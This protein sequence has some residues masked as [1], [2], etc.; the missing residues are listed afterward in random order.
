MKTI[1]A[2]R[3]KA[4]ESDKF[5]RML[6]ALG[7]G[8]SDSELARAAYNAGI[9]QAYKKLA[10]EKRQEA[11][12]TLER[13]GV[14]PSSGSTGTQTVPAD[15]KRKIEAEVVSQARRSKRSR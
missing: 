8:V 13:L 10:E 1:I 9:E 6:N 15:T 2:F 3:P 7:V 4:D 11:E 12:K 5:E 14:W